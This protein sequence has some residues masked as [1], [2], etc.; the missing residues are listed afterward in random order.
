MTRLAVLSLLLAQ[1][2]PAWAGE[3]SQ[4]TSP[5][6]RTSNRVTTLL[7]SVGNEANRVGP[8][9]PVGFT[10]A[11]SQALRALDEA[12]CKPRHNFVGSIW[13]PGG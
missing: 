11:G 4:G 10:Y 13:I 12:L 8:P 3:I 9:S 5:L 7:T 2:S 6:H 1:A